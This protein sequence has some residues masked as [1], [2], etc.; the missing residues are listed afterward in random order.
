MRSTILL[1]TL[2]LVACGGAAPLT[3]SDVAN[4][5]TAAG[6]EVSGIDNTPLTAPVP[7]SYSAHVRFT[8]TGERAQ[9]FICDTKRNCDAIYAYFDAL[10]GLGGPYYYQS[11]SGTVVVQ[12]SSQLPAD[13][14]SKY[15]AVV[16]GLP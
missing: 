1:L 10:K 2:L 3:T 4:R 9:I 6:L 5:F 8:V 14:A 12:M 11:S 7:K 16:R 13:V 15:E